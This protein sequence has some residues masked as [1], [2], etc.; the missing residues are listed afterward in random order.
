MP[1]SSNNGGGPWGSGDRGDRGRGERGKNP[2][3]SGGGG[4][5][6]P[7]GP[8]LDDLIRKGRDQL[9]VVL[10]GRGGGPPGSGRHRPGGG[11]GGFE[12]MLPIVLPVILLGICV[13]TSFYTVTMI[14][15][16][17]EVFL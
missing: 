13:F 6:K 15:N 10:G 2:W 17:V 12:R 11:G 8:D 7:P 9:R 3:G 4:G 5:G 1:F 14:E 16:Y